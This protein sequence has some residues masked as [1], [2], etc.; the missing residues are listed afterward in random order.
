L[1]SI[2]GSCGAEGV[3][4]AGAEGAGGSDDNGR[5][6]APNGVEGDDVTGPGTCATGAE[7]T[8]ARASATENMTVDAR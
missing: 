5:A 2:D 1:A 6:G 4:D 7:F 3:E 8:C